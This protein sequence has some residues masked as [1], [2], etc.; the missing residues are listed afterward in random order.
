MRRFILPMLLI[1]FMSCGPLAHLKKYKEQPVSA[2]ENQFGKPTTIIPL[3]DGKLYVYETTEELKGT[4]ISKGQTTLD[5][6]VSPATIK[7]EKL[8]FK[9]VD[10]VVVSVSREVDYKRK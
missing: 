5:P 3:D 2:I 8:I 6:M 7:T 9:V 10:G 1:F 4:E